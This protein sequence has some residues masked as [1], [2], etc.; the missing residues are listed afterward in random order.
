[1]LTVLSTGPVGFSDAPGETDAVLIG[2]TCDKAGNLL[3]PSKPLTACDSTHDEP[4]A[5]PAGFALSTYTAIGGAPWLHL[6]LTHQLE[7]PFAVRALDL[8][9]ALAP[10][11]TDAVGTWDSLRAGAGAGACGVTTLVAP[12]DPHATLLTLPPVA[13]GADPFYPTLT[14]F[15]PL[16]ASGVALFG[17]VD[18][19]TTI[20][21][22]RFRGA[23]QCTPDGLAFNVQGVAGE[24]IRL[25]WWDSAA[26]GVLAGN[27]TFAA[28]ATRQAC[29]IAGGELACAGTAQIA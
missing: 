28:G 9:P 20:S 10:G 17:E 3:Q 18:K 26:A 21:I 22:Q 12:A 4:G 15:A 14:L 24:T 16:C 5:A 29:T 8:Y 23:A 2:R 13:K 19:I 6:L 7:K 25:A 27:A 11:A 1:M